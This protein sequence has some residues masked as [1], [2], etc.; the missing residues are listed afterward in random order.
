MNL[1]FVVA[2]F[3]LM[4]AF[5]SFAAGSVPASSGTSLALG[6]LLL[7]AFFVGK[8]FSQ[9][10]LPKLTGYIAA[11]LC[12]GPSGLNLITEPMVNSLKL[13]N[14]MAVA[15]IALTA[16]AELE[17]R[18][19]RPLF[20]T[21]RWITLTGV[22]GTAVLLATV[23]F[24]T[25]RSLPFFAHFS[26]AQGLAVSAVLGVVMVAQSPAVV[27]ALRN[28]LA[29]E[30][31]VTRTV[32]GVVVIAD[33]LVIVL[34][35]A[36]SSVAKALLG[37]SADVFSTLTALAWELLGS[38]IVGVLLGYLLS[39]YLKRVRT[40]AA[41]FLLT[42]AFV[43]AEVGH[44]LHFDPLLIALAA[45]ALI[46]NF[47]QAG[48][49]VH[50]LIE[51]SAMPVYVLFFAVAGATLHLDALAAVGLPALLFVVVRAAGLLAGARVGSALAGAED[52]VKRYAGFGLLPQAGL[53][54]ALS[55]LFAKTF[56]EFGADAAALTF[57]VV[58]I[59]EVFAPAI[60]RV[61]LLRSGEAHRR[62]QAPA[63]AEPLPAPE[64]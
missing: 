51:G 19:M 17:L 4:H 20:R 34:F 53:A 11:G 35:A 7:T 12:V 45:G 3:G 36:T 22:V 9:I 30:G 33:L 23:V 29:S 21:I 1:L 8:V 27:V 2:L 13:V 41:V 39:A 56:P 63:E 38:L 42:L 60:Y 46:R 15:L 57:T 64:H 54:L 40:G 10:G 62:T 32:L 28:E 18:A 52:R 16:G 25:R 55:M 26:L 24:L 59:N 47:T 58:A 49:D 44:R 48:D 5:R 37:G 14:G 43:I 50:R 31:A 61:A 6:Y